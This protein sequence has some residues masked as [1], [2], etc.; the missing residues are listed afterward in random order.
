MKKFIVLAVI[1][2]LGV[3]GWA[4]ATYFVGAN[5]Q[6]RYTGLIDQYGHFG[7]FTLTTQSYDKEEN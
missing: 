1:V 2:L 5:V 7:P 6:S 4:G 3:A